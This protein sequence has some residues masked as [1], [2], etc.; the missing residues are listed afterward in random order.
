MTQII[1]LRDYI[2]VTDSVEEDSDPLMHGRNPG[3]RRGKTVDGLCAIECVNVHCESGEEWCGGVRGGSV[4]RKKCYHG[5]CNEETH[6]S[7]S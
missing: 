1:D 3:R 4:E 6:R 2:V 7:R 5:D